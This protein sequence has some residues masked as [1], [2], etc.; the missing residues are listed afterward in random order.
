[1][2]KKLYL[3]RDGIINE[4]IP[5]VGTLERFFWHYEIITIAKYFVERNYKVIVI[6][7]QSGIERGYYS[8]FDFY[9]LSGY[10]ID[11]FAKNDI[12]IEVR[13]CPHL[14]ERN[15]FY[16]KPNIGMINDIRDKNDILIGDKELDMLTAKNGNIK[17]RWLISK[18]EKSKYAS[19]IYKCHKELL[20]ELG[21]YEKYL[22]YNFID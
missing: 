7:N 22:Q 16:R 18:K 14:P 12:E 10:M 3:D 6:T 2:A 8:L 19:K 15:C 13:A 9:K 17:K 5:Y 21:L 4:Q 11:I 1:M 20:L